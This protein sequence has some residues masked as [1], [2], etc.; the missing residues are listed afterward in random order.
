MVFQREGDD[1]G[2]IL[3]YF[4]TLRYIFPFSRKFQRIRQAS[5]NVNG[6]IETIIDKYLRTFDEN[7]VR[8]FLDLYFREMVKCTPQE[9]N[10]TFQRKHGLRVSFARDLMPFLL[11]DRSLQMINYCSG[12]SISSFP[13]FPVRRPR[14][15]CCSSGSCTTRPSSSGCSGK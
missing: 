15:P 11:F 1:Y 10:F 6:F 14:W 13:P 4:P 9:P 7:H 12:W 2:T 5:M 8:C 3:S